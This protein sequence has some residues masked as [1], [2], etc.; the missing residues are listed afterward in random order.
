MANLIRINGCPIRAS[1]LAG[2]FDSV[3]ECDASDTDF[4][5][6]TIIEGLASASSSLVAV[7]MA[8]SAAR[9]SRREVVRRARKG[10][11]FAA[12]F[13]ERPRAFTMEIPAAGELLSPPRSRPHSNAKRGRLRSARAAAVMGDSGLRFDRLQEGQLGDVIIQPDLTDFSAFESKADRTLQGQPAVPPASDWT[14]SG[15]PSS[16]APR[17]G[18]GACWISPSRPPAP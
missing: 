2:R 15:T 14:N 16:R 4:G 9:L 1:S 13:P 7:L 17:R 11:E 8:Y 6:A 12:A 10:M 18:S 5:A 3:A